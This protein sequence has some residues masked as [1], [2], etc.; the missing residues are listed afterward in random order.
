MGRARKGAKAKKAAPPGGAVGAMV[1]DAASSLGGALQTPET[2]VEKPADVVSALR[3]ACASFYAAAKV[4]QSAGQARLFT[5]GSFTS[6]Q[7]LPQL[8]SLTDSV[9]AQVESTLADYTTTS[10]QKDAKS[11]EESEGPE[12]TDDVDGEGAEASLEMEEDEDE[13]EDEGDEMSLDE[14]MED[15]EEMEEG[16][17]GEESEEEDEEDEEGGA[18]EEE[19]MK[20]KGSRINAAKKLVCGGVIV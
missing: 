1:A 4:G 15:L 18:L 10:P 5:A 9:C 8:D 14:E 12:G 19:M 2:F 13:D 3:G 20:H 16:E 6:D 17:E 11:S 7:I